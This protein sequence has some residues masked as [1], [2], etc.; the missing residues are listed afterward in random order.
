[1]EINPLSKK[2][3][4]NS[5]IGHLKKKVKKK[6]MKKEILTSELPVNNNPTEGEL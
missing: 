2:E 3:N 1:M 5:H 4:N 6:T